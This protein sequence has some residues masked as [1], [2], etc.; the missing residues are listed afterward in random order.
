M[1][2]VTAGLN[3]AHAGEQPRTLETRLMHASRPVKATK[4]LSAEP[5]SSGVV[6][7]YGLT[8][9]HFWLALFSEPPG[10]RYWVPGAFFFSAS[11]LARRAS[12]N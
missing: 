10:L 11:M 5:S 12:L 9:T 1:R 3:A 2:V 4:D 6:M 7:I 8:G